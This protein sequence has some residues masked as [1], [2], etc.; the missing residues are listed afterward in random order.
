MHPD[1]ENTIE[2]H[3]A[4]EINSSPDKTPLLKD[5]VKNSGEQLHLMRIRRSY[6]KRLIGTDIKD[7]LRGEASYKLKKHYGF[8]KFRKDELFFEAEEP[9]PQ[10][11]KDCYS[12]DEL[13]QIIP[14]E[15]EI[16]RD[17]L[18]L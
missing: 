16:E 9:T 11:P 10:N 12:F 4:D 18:I 7:R 2:K 6:I 3:I 8:F 14:T 1:T 15:A 13:G 17:L 5:I